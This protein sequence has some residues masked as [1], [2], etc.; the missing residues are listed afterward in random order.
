MN[1]PQPNHNFEEQDQGME[2]ATRIGLQLLP[3]NLEVD[4]G[5]MDYGLR[6]GMHGKHADGAAKHFAPFGQLEGVPVP[7]S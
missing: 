2:E 7:E 5:L 3:E 4:P 6:Q 1:N